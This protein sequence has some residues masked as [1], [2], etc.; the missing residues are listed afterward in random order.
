[1]GNMRS[2]IANV[3]KQR[4]CAN[5]KN[6]AP[7]TCCLQAQPPTPNHPRP[8]KKEG[9]NF[10]VNTWAR[11]PSYAHM[12]DGI[13]ID[14]RVQTGNEVSKHCWSGGRCG[15]RPPPRGPPL[16]NAPRVSE[17]CWGF[18]GDIATL[19]AYVYVNDVVCFG[20]AFV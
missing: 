2:T 18:V 3:Q 7:R 9:K 13:T 8:P 16:G 1:M 17:C 20:I 11:D 19:P 6:K 10:S 15:T 4:A 14:K 12:G 5:C